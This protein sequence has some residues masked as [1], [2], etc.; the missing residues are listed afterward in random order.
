MNLAHSVFIGNL[1]MNVIDSNI[2]SVLIPQY[3]KK[4]FLGNNTTTENLKGFTT[5]ICVVSEEKTEQE[6]RKSLW[7][8]LKN[9]NLCFMP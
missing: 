7:L 6:V 5:N 4:S 3:V 1:N 2:F 9:P 8:C